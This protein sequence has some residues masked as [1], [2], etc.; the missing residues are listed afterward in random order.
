MGQEQLN[1]PLCN[2]LSTETVLELA[3]VQDLEDVSV[4][5]ASSRG[6][7]NL[8]LSGTVNF[9]RLV[10]LEV[11][12]L[13]SN[14]L[15]SVDEILSLTSLLELNLDNNYIETISH[16]GQLHNL[17]KLHVRNNVLD[18]LSGIHKLTKLTT[19]SVSGNCWVLEEALQELKLCHKLENLD[20][21]E[22][23]EV[24]DHI[25]WLKVL[26]GN[27]LHTAAGSAYDHVLLSVKPARNLDDARVSLEDRVG[28]LET[29]NARLREDVACLE[30]DAELQA[31][32]VEVAALR[33]LAE[34]NTRLKAEIAALKKSKPVNAILAKQLAKISSRPQTP[35]APFRE[36][37]ARETIAGLS[38]PSTAMSLP[39]VVEEAEDLDL[40]RLLEES[41]RNLIEA[42]LS[43]AETE[44]QFGGSR[45]N[46]AASY[47]F[48]N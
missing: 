27:P 23:F 2:V 35:M 4:L 1:K 42:E 19:L 17:H 44:K 5:N 25:P 46:T 30:D 39:H 13:S 47:N 37:T 16:F 26:D 45:A 20:F 3:D 28:F 22:Y 48:T 10:R 21:G 41:E 12:D 43:L 7:W 32:R 33:V 29:E 31:L 11:L 38:R 15:R 36:T 9:G 18:N 8:S 6:L 24:K 40:D 14:K 34:E